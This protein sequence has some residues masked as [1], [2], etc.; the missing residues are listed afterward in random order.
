MK[1][2]LWRKVTL[3]NYR[4]IV[5]FSVLGILTVVLAAYRFWGIPNGLSPAEMTAATVSGQFSFSAMTSSFSAHVA[6]LVGLPWTL[7]QMVSINIFGYSTFAM[8]LPA[9]ILMVLSIAGLVVVGYKSFNKN[10]AIISGFLIVPSVIF[11]SLSRSGDGSAMTIFLM[12]AALLS[13]VSA[14]QCESDAMKGL[15][16]IGVCVALCA[17]IYQPGGLFILA[18]AILI[19]LLHPKT[20]LVIMSSKILNLIIATVVG[21]IFLAPLVIGL[22]ADPNAIVGGL[23]YSGQWSVD[24]I[25]GIGISL[26]GV[27]EGFVGGMVTPIV[28]VTFLVFAI[29]GLARSI[30]H[31]LSARSH[32]TLSSTL[33]FVGLAILQPSFVFLLFLPLCLLSMIGVDV[34]IHEWNG[35]F[36]KNPYPRVLATAL[37]VVVIFL[38]LCT[39]A[40]HY[41]TANMYDSLAVSNY[42]PEFEAARSVLDGDDDVTLVVPVGQVDFYSNLGV[43][44]STKFGDGVNVVLNSVD[45][46]V[47]PEKA[48]PAKIITGPSSENPVL[49]RVYSISLGS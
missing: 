18:V 25:V 12:V 36:P 35:L 28:S 45:N 9:V 40:T 21:V 32:L 37:I 14:M 8:R 49:L 4:Y 39:A 33:L 48:I 44:V 41:M 31:F 23:L 34:V 22:F 24:N 1:K 15:A 5:G 27:K 46:D 19:S 43:N 10:I 47:I 11:M 29:I 13:A 42:N 30:Q 2:D 17:L 20:R 3:H 26:T 7:I 16:K 6:W 38:N